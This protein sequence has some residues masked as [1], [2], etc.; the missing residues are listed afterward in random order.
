MEMVLV[1]VAA[2]NFVWIQ[3]KVGLIIMMTHIQTAQ[4]TTLI[5]AVYVMGMMGYALAVQIQMLLTLT[6]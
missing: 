5:L 2:K 3:E 1:T 6:V 4:V